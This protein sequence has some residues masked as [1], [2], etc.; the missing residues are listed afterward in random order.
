METGDKFDNTVVYVIVG[1]RQGSINDRVLKIVSL[2]KCFD[3][4]V[5]VRIGKRHISSELISVKPYPNPTQVLN[6]MHL[7][8]LKKKID[9][10]IFFPSK[11]ILF[12]K[13]VKKILAENI[14][15]DLKSGKQVCVLTITPPHDITLVGKY[16]KLK[17]SQIRWIIDWQDLWSYDENYVQRIPLI[18][19]NR[20]LRLEA[21]V[22]RECDL[23]I[24]TNTY[25]KEVVEKYYGVPSER[26]VS[27]NH[28]FNRDDLKL[29]SNDS[30]IHEQTSNNDV[31]RIGFLGI[32]F[33]PP[34]VPGDKVMNAI[35]HVKNSGLNVELHLFGNLP[36]VTKLLKKSI[37]DGVLIIH[38]KA[39]H[40]ESLQRLGQCDFLLLALSD[41]R[42]CRAV[43]SIKLPHYLMLGH[44]IIAIVPEKSATAE[45]I[46]ETGSGFVIPS[47][48]NWGEELKR[49]LND[50]LSK[51]ISL[52]RNDQIIESYSWK[53]ISMQW[54]QVLGSN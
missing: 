30:K 7:F 18:Y 28:H 13:R 27:I 36:Q 52:Q 32:L 29:N 10:Y 50:S 47:N 46:T 12:V 25:A 35:H 8:G 9:R 23:N 2:R 26:V 17:Y 49:I 21:K 43:M 11:A 3:K 48:D 20:M 40:E 42:N 37:Q 31:I 39:S 34:R 15:E 4:L 53:N 44:P 24:T 22:F 19:R 38:G 1:K 54:L 16:L 33:K 45:I 41:L 6:R 51:K 5:L 14:A